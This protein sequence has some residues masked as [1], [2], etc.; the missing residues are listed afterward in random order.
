MFHIKNI[1]FILLLCICNA[2]SGQLIITTVAGDG[3]L[4]YNGDGDS[5]VDAELF[6]P[7][8]ARPDNMGNLYIA[9]HGNSRIRMVNSSDIISTVVGNGTPAHSGDGGPAA[10]AEL[11]YPYSLTFD[12]YGN[13]YIA[14]NVTFSGQGTGG[15]AWIRKVN[16]AGIITTIIG[17]GISGDGG[18]GGPASAAEFLHISDIAVDT[19]GNIYI[20][21]NLDNKVR[22]VNTAGII[23]TLA[24]I[25]TPNY[26]GDGGPADSA[27]LNSPF[28]VAVDNKGNVYIADAQNSCIR[29]V[30]DSGIISTFAGNG[31]IGI[32]GDGG[33]ATAADLNDPVSVA[34]DSLGNVYIADVSNRSIRKVDTSGIITTIA[35][36]G[37]PGYSGDGGLATAAQFSE[38]YG[39]AADLFG[40]IYIDDV[41]NQD[42]R[43]A[44]PADTLLAVHNF[45]KGA[46]GMNIWPLP[47]DGQFTINISAAANEQVQI[48]ITNA[49]GQEIKQLNSLT[50]KATGITLDAPPGMYFLTAIT[51][52]Y[53]Q[54]AKITVQ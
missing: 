49:I 34:V 50:N 23:T 39:V 29:K 5:A 47:N 32:T 2:A 16:T 26:T 12:R 15:G 36:N 8:C 3:N 18:D 37:T 35:G 52:L 6:D 51:G 20:V 33:Q 7:H 30:N 4:G 44:Y 31:T 25:G 21:D 27:Q 45:S 1:L 14:E 9:D 46:Y 10:D 22:V 43:M 24:G 42:I 11:F 17:N 13:L 40:D 53:S 38:P 54:S 19:A 41:G 28:G 48:I